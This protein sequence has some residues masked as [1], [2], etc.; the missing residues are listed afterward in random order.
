[1][2]KLP[3]EKEAR[4]AWQPLVNLLGT[5]TYKLISFRA[6]GSIHRARASNY[7]PWQ[8]NP[9]ILFVVINL[10]YAWKLFVYGLLV[11]VP[12]PKSIPL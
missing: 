10:L 9:K 6:A 5:R 1:M 12:H 3:L 8:R 7:A 2:M 4:V 11:K